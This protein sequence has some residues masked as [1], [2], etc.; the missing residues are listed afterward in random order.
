[1]A[2]TT[3]ASFQW[4]ELGR[5]SVEVGDALDAHGEVTVVRGSQMLSLAVPTERSIMDTLRE[6]CRVLTVLVND[7]DSTHVTKIL[8]EAWPWT[9]ALPL[10]DQ[11]VFAREVGSVAEMC[12]SLNSWR[13]LIDLVADWRRTA[14]AWA[15]GEASLVRV[16]TPVEALAT[17]P[18]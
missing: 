17:R 11:I 5:R 12:E 14:R 15:D 13:Q 18:A 2:R 6:M 9:R 16:E 4:S 7:D 1:M 3:T 10:E 8:N